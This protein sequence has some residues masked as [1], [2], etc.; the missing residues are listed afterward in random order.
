MS[1]GASAQRELSLQDVTGVFPTWLH[2]ESLEP[3]D[4][5]LHSLETSMS[6][7]FLLKLPAVTGDKRFREAA[8][9]AVDAMLVKIVPEGQWE[10]L[11]IGPAITSE[12]KNAMGSESR[13]MGCSRSAA[14]PRSG[15]PRRCWRAAAKPAMRATCAGDGARWINC[16]CPN[17][18]GS[19][20]QI[21][22]CDDE[23]R[24]CR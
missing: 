24:L 5:L 7:A 9:R 20:T 4:A 11:N 21:G 16:R 12:K 6:V 22:P 15:R 14:F 1:R 2:P 8:I 17:R 13:T 10:D 3:A 19:R 23:A 18:S